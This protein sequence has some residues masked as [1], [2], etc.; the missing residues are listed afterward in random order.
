[1]G[2]VSMNFWVPKSWITVKPQHYQMDHPR[3]SKKQVCS[4]DRHIACSHGQQALGA[5]LDQGGIS[6]SSAGWAGLV[7]YWTAST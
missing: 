1:M 5:E 6:V 7:G 3:R 2:F 4:D